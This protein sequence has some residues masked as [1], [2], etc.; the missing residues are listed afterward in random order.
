[1]LHSDVRL[2]GAASVRHVLRHLDVLDRACPYWDVSTLIGDNWYPNG[3]NRYH[4]FIAKVGATF[5]DISVMMPSWAQVE[6]L[7]TRSKSLAINDYFH[8]VLSEPH[9]DRV[10][11]MERHNRPRPRQL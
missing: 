3:D 11:G 5:V 6:R 9:C 1:M 4:M 10:P 2:D 7:A 8:Y